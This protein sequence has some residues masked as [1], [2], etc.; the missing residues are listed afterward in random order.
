MKNNKSLKILSWLKKRVK[1]YFELDKKHMRIQKNTGRY[2]NKDRTDV[3]KENL[4]LG[5]KFK[6]KF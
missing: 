3:I 2:D 1:P 6:W 5:I 4:H